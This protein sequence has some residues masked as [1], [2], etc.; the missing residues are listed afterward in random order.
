MATTL[1]IGVVDQTAKIQHQ[2]MSCKLNTLDLVLVD[3]VTVPLLGDAVALTNPTWAGSVAS[4]TKT[5]P[6]DRAGHVLVKIAATNTAVATAS[7]APF[8]LSDA[9][10]NSTTY[11]YR[12]LSVAKQANQDGTTSTHGGCVINQAGLWPA[13]TFLLTS[14]NMGYAGSGFSVTNVTVTWPVAGTPLYAI[15]FGDAIVTMAVWAASQ[16]GA[17]PPGSIDGTRITPLTVDTPQLRAN[18]VIGDKILAGS[19]TADKLAATLV[20]AS[21]LKT[22]APDG[23]DPG[24]GLRVELDLNGLRAFDAANKLQVKI[25]TD[26]S[27]VFVSGQVAASTLTATLSTLLQGSALLG[28]GATMTVQNNVANPSQAPVLVGSVPKL[29][30]T[31]TPAHSGSGL[32]YEPAGYTDARPTYWLGATADDGSTTDVAYE[33]DA[34][35]GALLRTLRKTGS[36]A[37]YTTTLGSSSHVADRA[38]GAVG[39][40]NSQIATP[41]TFPARNGITITKVSVYMAGR[42]GTCQVKNA[43]WNT[44]GTLLRESAAYT[45]ASGGATTVG[46][47]DHHDVAL[48]S[49]LAVASGATIWAGFL[50]PGTSD[51]SQY[52]VDTGSNTTKIGQGNDG[53][54]TSI[55]TVSTEKPNVYVT[56]QYT[57]DSSLEGTMGTIVGA[58]RQGTNVWVLDN[59]GTLFQYSQADLSYLGKTTAIASLITGAKAGAGL[60]WDGTN[61]VVTTASGTTGTDQ[62]RFL[63]LTTA[64]AWSSTLNATGQAVNGSTASI[65]GGCLVNDALNAS[66][67]TYW[68]A[69]GGTLVGVHG[70]VASSGAHTANRDFGVAGEI[71]GGVAWDGTSFRGWAAANATSVWQFTSWDWST[72]TLAYWLA[73]TWLDDVGTAHETQ[74]SPR[75]SIALGRRRQLSVTVP[76][77]PVGGVDDP[78]KLNLYMAASAT[79]PGATNLKLQTAGGTASTSLTLTSFN[80]AGA[81]DPA[82]NNFPGGTPAIIRSQIA[83]WSLKGD[84]TVALNPASASY[85][86]G[87]SAQ[88]TTITTAGT[89]YALTA[90]EVSFTPAFVGQVWLL[91][92]TTNLSHSS[93]TAQYAI[94]RADLTDA[95]NAQIAVM[96]YVRNDLGASTKFVGGAAHLVWTA[97]R[98][99]ACKIKLYG[100]VQTTN[101]TTLSV[102]YTRLSAVALG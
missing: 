56:Y 99:T 60:F 48:T 42:L 62:V 98:T 45:A 74:V 22:A 9:P 36:T 30:L 39:T 61:L 6:V 24:T 59:L 65:R 75:A 41:L 49:P 77:I 102:A 86:L 83:G 28:V 37:T 68:V 12:A 87:G 90:Q 15:E 53:S 50:R 8:G 17:A 7:S 57:V 43:V 26:G 14:A 16:A 69:L 32:C 85:S 35:T 27:A 71:A 23:S 51:G 94:V 13:M 54:M 47:S 96:D 19:I 2:S 33:F 18:A 76:A 29:A 66:A 31:S 97:D 46:A 10:D 44:S 84:G 89:Y 80:A 100:T 4:I 40:T 5:D 21:L 3:P 25:P 63:K 91:I 72:A 95:S 70:F 78:D 1:T 101:G 88:A 73:Y 92:A 20:L 81:A 11:G 64:G 38:N 79:D 55:S 52:D 82:A 58:A 67:P 34:A 93:A